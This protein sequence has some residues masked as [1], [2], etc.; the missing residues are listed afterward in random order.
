MLKL[1]MNNAALATLFVAGLAASA[2]VALVPPAAHAQDNS[3]AAYR[4]RDDTRTHRDR[5]D[6]YRFHRYH[7]S[8]YHRDWI[9]IGT[10]GY[11]VGFYTN[12]YH[13]YCSHWDHTYGYC[14][15]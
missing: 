2:V 14:Y 15:W 7:S 10:P 12:P 3:G 9:G 13:H 4:D 11:G 1:T 8:A 6:Y 5:D